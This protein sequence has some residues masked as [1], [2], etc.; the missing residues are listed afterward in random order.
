MRIKKYILTSLCVFVLLIGSFTACKKKD[1]AETK[2]SEEAISTASA[3][4]SAEAVNPPGETDPSGTEA[5]KE[6][7]TQVEDTTP[8]ETA[9]KR[10]SL[11]FRIQKPGENTI[12]EVSDEVYE[13]AS[14]YMFYAFG[15]DTYNDAC[16]CD[17]DII[18]L[19]NGT[20][21]SD[22]M[23]DMLRL[24]DFNV[25]QTEDTKIYRSINGMRGYRCSMSDMTFE[26]RDGN[27]INGSGFAMV[28]GNKNDV[29]LYVVLGILKAGSS[30]AT[31]IMEQLNASALSLQSNEDDTLELWTETMPDGQNV[32]AIFKKEAILRYD[33]ESD[34]I[35]LY[36]NESEEGYFL[37]RHFKFAVR[38]TSEEQLRSLIAGVASDV[39]V[40][41]V[42]EVRGKQ[43]YS[44]VELSSTVNGKQMQEIICVTVNE[45]G[46]TWLIDLYGTVEEVEVQKENLDILLWSL[47][48]D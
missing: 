27:I 11:S 22:V 35:Y 36:Y 45:E 23:Y 41:D 6:S 46:S 34:G 32:K 25:S 42:T 24:R 10:S 30:D 12:T 7:D 37:I 2:N 9:Y 26:D 14:D 29:G 39:Q 16:V 31:R 20:E 38:S 5:T 33:K 8:A 4:T 28:Y 47:T 48:E 44:M 13:N 17:T 40:S 3:D 43:S 1:D 18:A 15:M 21:K 19:L